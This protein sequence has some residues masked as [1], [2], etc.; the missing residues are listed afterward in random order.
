MTLYDLSYR[1]YVLTRSYD[2]QSPDH[3]QCHKNIEQAIG[4]ARG[5]LGPRP[6]KGSGKNC[7]TILAVQKGQIYT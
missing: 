7:T 3:T 4:I 2:K 6:L 5:V 1:N